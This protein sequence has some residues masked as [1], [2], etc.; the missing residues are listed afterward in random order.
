MTYYY[1]PEPEPRYYPITRPPP[2]AYHAPGR[3]RG[4]IVQ[5]GGPRPVSPSPIRA[6]IIEK[7]RRREPQGLLSMLCGAV[8]CFWV[9][10]GCAE[11]CCP[12]EEYDSD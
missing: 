11:G 10:S 2:R 8:C 9:C 6:V 7:R 12:A 1:R 5:V 3:S 4:V